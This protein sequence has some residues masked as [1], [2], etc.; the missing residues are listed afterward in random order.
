LKT[1]KIGIVGSRR[2]NTEKDKQI[3]KNAVMHFST[4]ECELVLVSGGCPKGAD[5]FA[6]ELAKE[7]NLP[8]KIHYPDKSKLEEDTRWAYTK[9]YFERNTLIAQD[10]D[11]LLA[12]P[13][14]DRKG[15]TEDTIKKATALK[16]PVVL[17]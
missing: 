10:C 14:P 1:I 15:G 11:I 6:E 8:I 17:L 5:R 2:R 12:L 13:A 7:L 4:K 9:I 3:V 16:K